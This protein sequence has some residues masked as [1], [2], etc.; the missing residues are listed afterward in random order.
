M[1]KVLAFLMAAVSPTVEGMAVLE[2]GEGITVHD[3]G[4]GEKPCSCVCLHLIGALARVSRRMD[5]E[6]SPAHPGWVY[7]D[8]SRVPI[9]RTSTPAGAPSCAPSCP[10]LDMTGHEPLVLACG[11]AFGS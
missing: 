3:A 10:G 5:P 6:K 7:E 8:R 9:G 4:R 1:G 2:I 11:V